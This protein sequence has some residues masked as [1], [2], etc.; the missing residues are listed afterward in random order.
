MSR[1]QRYI[2]TGDLFDLDREKKAR[3][4]GMA[5]AAA[6]QESPLET[7]RRIAREIARTKG[8][9]SADDVQAVLIPMG[10]DLGNC[11]RQFVSWRWLAVR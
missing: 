8:E 7:G 2:V 3:D 1:E 6:A 10:I 11:C 4:V 5:R 9:V